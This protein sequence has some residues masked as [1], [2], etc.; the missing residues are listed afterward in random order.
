M[1][2]H[3]AHPI[4]FISDSFVV[5]LLLTDLCVVACIAWDTL[6]HRRLNPVLAWGG[7]LIMVSEGFSTLSG[8]MGGGSLSMS[9]RLKPL[10]A[11]TTPIP[12]PRTQF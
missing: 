10:C 5:S 1:A 8:A 9:T 7:G 6:R 2:T 11:T 3:V 12:K 4:A